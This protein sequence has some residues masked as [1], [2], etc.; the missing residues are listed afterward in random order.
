MVAKMEQKKIPY[1]NIVGKLASLEV[2]RQRKSFVEIC[3]EDENWLRSISL[4]F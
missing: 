2:G 4:W 1:R 3:Y